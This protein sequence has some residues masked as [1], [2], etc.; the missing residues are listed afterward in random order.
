M[1]EDKSV[2]KL[3]DIFF[4]FYTYYDL[5]SVPLVTEITQP[6]ENVEEGIVFRSSV[7]SQSYKFSI[8]HQYLSGPPPA[9]GRCSFLGYV[10]QKVKNIFN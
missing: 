4:I 1:A 7:H 5:C 10:A 2:E 9:V 6:V 3:T 8:K